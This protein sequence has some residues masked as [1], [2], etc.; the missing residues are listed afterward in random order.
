MTS[1]WCLAD[2]SHVVLK[3]ID[4]EGDRITIGER[5]D[6]IEARRHWQELGDPNELELHLSIKEVAPPDGSQMVPGRRILHPKRNTGAL[7]KSSVPLTAGSTVH[8]FGLVSGSYFHSNHGEQQGMSWGG[9]R[10][11]LAWGLE[12]HGAPFSGMEV[13]LRSRVTGLYFHSNHDGR[14][15]M[16]WGGKRA[17]LGWILSWEA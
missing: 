16:S 7:T 5:E 11:D 8:L 6:L 15:G 2:S 10:P 1:S 12:Y 13:E 3:W 17:D 14:M 9:L 4:D